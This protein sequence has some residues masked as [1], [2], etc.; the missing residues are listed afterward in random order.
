MKKINLFSILAFFAVFL[1][2]T[3]NTEAK[4]WRVNN[5]SNYNGTTQW[6]S[7]FGGNPGYPVFNQ[8][9]QAIAWSS[10]ADSDT[11]HVEGSQFIYA[12]AT[13]TKKVVLIG[14]GFFL[15]DNLKT[16]HYMLDAKIT[17]VNFN[18]GSA[19]SSVIGLN[20]VVNTN[21]ADGYIQI[22]ADYIT[23][24]RC[25][26]ERSVYF[27]ITGGSGIQRITIVQNYFPD[28]YVTNP[29][30]FTNNNF[31]P[32]V[33][34][35]F[36]NNICRKTLVW[37]YSNSSAAWNITQCK[38]NVFDGPD[39]LATP[40]LRFTTTDFSNNIL[41]PVNAIVD[42]IAAP[43]QIAYNIGTQSTQFG[44]S[45]NNLVI[46]DI[47]TLFVGGNSRDGNYQIKSDSQAYQNG[48]DGSDRG[49]FGG[50]IV[51]S[52]YAL[53]GLAPVPVIYEATTTGVVSATTGLPVTI[54]ARTIK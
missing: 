15:P 27:N 35:I 23:I 32:P 54:K 37:H 2:C 20:V 46:P 11:I 7:N 45:N 47:A 34:I 28:N 22:A 48:S 10:V 16:G 6:G 33:E 8:V 1:F 24:K 53:S 4:I 50:A 5:G 51:S 14:P 44:T 21:T 18:A 42:I 29:L 49:A 31:V 52:R 36:N 19:G 25:R 39:N 12:A 17:R 3:F 43:G 38:N 26:I 9:N 13:I 41:M 30:Y 40:N